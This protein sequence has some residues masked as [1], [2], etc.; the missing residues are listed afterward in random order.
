MKATNKSHAVAVTRSLAVGILRSL[1]TCTSRQCADLLERGDDASV[2]E[3][4]VVYDGEWRDFMKNYLAVELVSKAD[5]LNLPG[6]RRSEVAIQKFLDSEASCYTTNVK[7]VS[8]IRDPA[9]PSHDVSSVFHRAR[10]KIA[11]ILGE[12]SWDEAERCMA[13]GP[14]ASIG[15]TRQKCHAVHKFGLRRPTVTGECATVAQLLIGRCPQWSKTVPVTSGM[16]ED[17]LK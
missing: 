3:L 14:G 17:C 10:R 11:R 5:W 13:F 7:F 9:W 2:L 4:T 6:I 1:D 15:V 12:F 8:A 16:T